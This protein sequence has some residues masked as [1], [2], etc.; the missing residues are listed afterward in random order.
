[1]AKEKLTKKHVEYLGALDAQIKGLEEERDTLKERFREEYGPEVNVKG[2]A[3]VV[4]IGKVGQTK[5]KVDWRARWVASHSEAEADRLEEKT[6]KE[7]T[8]ERAAMVSIKLNPDIK[9]DPDLLLQ[10][11]KALEEFNIIA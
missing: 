8:G 4:S 11:K 3:F 6:G 10:S 1:M 9:K 5:A 2:F 7:I